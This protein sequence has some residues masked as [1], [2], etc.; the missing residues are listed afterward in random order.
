MFRRLSITPLLEEYIGR[1]AVLIG[2][3]PKVML[4]SLGLHKH[5]IMKK[6]SPN[7]RF[8]LKR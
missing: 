2:G 1:L 8:F 4:L 6:A 5:L 7:P 3:S